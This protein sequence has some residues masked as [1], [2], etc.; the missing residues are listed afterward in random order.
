MRRVGEVDLNRNDLR[1]LRLIELD[2]D[3]LH[4]FVQIMDLEDMITCCD[5]IRFTLGLSERK[6]VIQRESLIAT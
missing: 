3:V 5:A 6:L 2:M 4:F 1:G